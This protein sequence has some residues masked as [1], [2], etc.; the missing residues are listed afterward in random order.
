MSERVYRIDCTADSRPF[1]DARDIIPLLQGINA[2]P[3]MKVDSKTIS[4]ITSIFQSIVVTTERVQE[5][6][7]KI[8]RSHIL[9]IHKSV[10]KQYKKNQQV[11]LD[12]S[13]VSFLEEESN[14]ED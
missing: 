13:E 12:I 9:K 8:K 14:E 6:V 4:L 3:K 11:E 5:D 1:V 2:D 10:L 7:I